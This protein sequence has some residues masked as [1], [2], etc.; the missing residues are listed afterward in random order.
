M[1]SSCSKLPYTMT[2]F[3]LSRQTWCSTWFWFYERTFSSSECFCLKSRHKWMKENNKISTRDTYIFW[4]EW[5]KKQNFYFESRVVSRVYYSILWIGNAN[6]IC[7]SCCQNF[8]HSQ[9]FPIITEA[10]HVKKCWISSVITQHHQQHNIASE[11]NIEWIKRIVDKMK[12]KEICNFVKR[13]FILSL[14]FRDLL[15]GENHFSQFTKKIVQFFMK[16]KSLK[17][18]VFASAASQPSCR[19]PGMRVHYSQIG[20][21]KPRCKQWRSATRTWNEIKGPCEEVE[22]I[23]EWYFPSNGVIWICK[24]ILHN[25]CIFSFYCALSSSLLCS[26]FSWLFTVFISFVGFFIVQRCQFV[27]REFTTLLCMKKYIKSSQRKQETINFTLWKN[28]CVLSFESRFFFFLLV[29]NSIII[30][31]VKEFS[32]ILSHFLFCLTSNEFSWM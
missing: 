27:E 12:V 6:E 24:I 30:S 1:L 25:F 21:W 26:K 8:L 2:I 14:I 31:D 9:Q 20:A 15:L 5:E 28:L 23:W 11:N 32:F 10:S 19:L 18:T 3:S 4:K 7:L 22:N 13:N 17:K 16:M 29:A